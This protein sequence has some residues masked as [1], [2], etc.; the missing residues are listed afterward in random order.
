M[1]LHGNYTTLADSILAQI[2]AIIF[3]F[4]TVL[5]IRLNPLF[6]FLTILYVF[7]YALLKCFPVS[8]SYKSFFSFFANSDQLFIIHL[9]DRF[10]FSLAFFQIRKTSNVVR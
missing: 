2:I 10:L 1:F 8:S 5:L 4:I 6:I 7:C 3:F 9:M